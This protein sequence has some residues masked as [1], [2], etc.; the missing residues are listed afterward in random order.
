MVTGP[1]RAEVVE[2]PTPSVGATD[3]LVRMRACGICGSDTFYIARGGIPP[4]GDHVVINPIAPG[5]GL[6]GSGGPAGALA[7]EVLRFNGPVF[8][9]GPRYALEDV[10]VGGQQLRRGDLVLVLL[11]SANHDER[12]FTGPDELDLARTLSQHL[13]FGHGIH[14]CLGAPLARLEG[15]IA[16]EATPAN[17]F[18]RR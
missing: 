4:R 11:G 15:E 17:V 7:E 3:V 18:D 5:S 6:I 16:L 1:G 2:V 10:E 12:V 14:Y 13:A 9:A 8:S